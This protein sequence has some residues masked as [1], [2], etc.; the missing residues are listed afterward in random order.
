MADRDAVS[1]GYLDCWQLIVFA[2]HGVDKSRQWRERWW[3][4]DEQV[5]R[6]LELATIPIE[7]IRRRKVFGGIGRL[8]SSTERS[9]SNIC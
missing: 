7:P 6:E 8:R 2:I 9:I 3:G 5:H 4:V 1:E